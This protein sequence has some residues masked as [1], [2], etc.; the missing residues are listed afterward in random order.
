[1]HGVVSAEIPIY[2]HRAQRGNTIEG[3]DFVLYDDMQRVMLEAIAH[4]ERDYEVARLERVG[5]ALAV[6]KD[7]LEP[8]P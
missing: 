3:K 2:T 4:L 7:A 6:L 5:E 8:Q 1:V